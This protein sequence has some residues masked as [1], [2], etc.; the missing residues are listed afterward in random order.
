MNSRTTKC[1]P[2]SKTQ[3]SLHLVVFQE[4]LFL[5]IQVQKTLGI[6]LA[7]LAVKYLTFIIT[8]L[9]NH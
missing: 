7:C 5:N 9:P 6:A 1:G 2:P 4:I 3:P 8:N